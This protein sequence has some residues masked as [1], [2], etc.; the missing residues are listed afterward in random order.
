MR[1]FTEGQKVTPIRKSIGIPLH[2]CSQWK[3][4]KKRGYLYVIYFAGYEND[5]EGDERVYF[6]S[7]DGYSAGRYYLESDLI[8]FVD[9]I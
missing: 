7:Y 1:K 8:P 6:C 4:G 3:E 5:K 2:N 9:S